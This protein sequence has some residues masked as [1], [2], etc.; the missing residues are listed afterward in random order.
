MPTN[1]YGYKMRRRPLQPLERERRPY[2]PPQSIVNPI[3]TPYI[4]ALPVMGSGAHTL[5]YDSEANELAWEP[6]VT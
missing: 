3:Y 6:L 2:I 1:V 5:I 4:P